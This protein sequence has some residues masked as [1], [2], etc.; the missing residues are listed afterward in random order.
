MKRG[1]IVLCADRAADFTAKPRPVLI[2]QKSAYLTNKE[3]IIVCPIST[4][5]VDD[6]LSFRIQPTASNGLHQPSEIRADKVSTVKKSRIGDC[7]GAL[8]SDEMLR[9][10]DILRDWLAL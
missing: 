2:V 8:T 1:D 10:D 9:L 6:E 7:I 3:S 4:V 5:L